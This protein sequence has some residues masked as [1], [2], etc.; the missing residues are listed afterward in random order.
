MDVG[1]EIEFAKKLIGIG[2]PE[3][4]LKI[5]K[6]LLPKCEARGDIKRIISVREKIIE[7]VIDSRHY[8]IEELNTQHDKLFELYLT[9]GD[10]AAAAKCLCEQALMDGNGEIRYILLEKVISLFSNN[11]DKKILSVVE[12]AYS[13]IIDSCPL[14]EPYLIDVSKRFLSFL[15]RPQFPLTAGEQFL[16]EVYQWDAEQL[17][18]KPFVELVLDFIDKTEVRSRKLISLLARGHAEADEYEE[19]IMLAFELLFDTEDPERREYLKWIAE[20]FDA[21]EQP[22]NSMMFYKGYIDSMIETEE[23]EEKP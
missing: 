7:C 17:Y 3:R 2:E 23:D 8:D 11:S 14:E 13:S 12:C 5:L 20:W 18:G 9:L 22:L 19:A 15:A 16:D 1:K 21:I 10:K 6:H 4:A